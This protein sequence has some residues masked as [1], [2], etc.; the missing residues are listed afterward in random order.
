MKIT[1]KVQNNL[2]FW[3][4]LYNYKYLNFYKIITNLLYI[5]F[6]ITYLVSSELYTEVLL[7]KHTLRCNIM[8]DGTLENRHNRKSNIKIQVNINKQDLV[9]PDLDEQSFRG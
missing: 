8:L 6:K 2:Y 4:N 9:G 5:F 1:I 7:K 3:D